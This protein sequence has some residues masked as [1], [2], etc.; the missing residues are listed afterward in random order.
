MGEVASFQAAPSAI[1][2]ILGKRRHFPRNGRVSRRSLFQATSPAGSATPTDRVFPGEVA[3]QRAASITRWGSVPTSQVVAGRRRPAQ[4]TFPHTR[5]ACSGLTSYSGRMCLYEP[6]RFRR[7]PR[8]QDAVLGRGDSPLSCRDR[9]STPR[10]CWSA[11]SG[12]RWRVAG[13]S[14][15]WPR[16]WGSTRRRCGSGCGRRR[17]IAAGAAIC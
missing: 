13:R 10:S 8:F 14:R 16:I 4:A 9:G 6:G 5:A 11:A 17:P 3:R 7:R 15:M 2:R 12:W 1:L